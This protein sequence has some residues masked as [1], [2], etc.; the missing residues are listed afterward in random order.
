MFDATS[1]YDV[2]K[3]N[4]SY[5]WDFGD[6]ETSTEPVVTHIYEK[7]GQYTVK[8]T[9][10][11]DSG[12]PCDSASTTQTVYVNTPPKASFIGPSKV[13]KDDGVSFDASATTDDT[14]ENLTYLWNFGDGSRGEGE[15]VSHVYGKGGS[16]NVTLTVDDNSGTSCDMDSVVKQIKV[17]TPPVAV[18]GRDITMCLKDAEADYT[19]YLDGTSSRDAD[20]DQLKYTW[21]LG[22]GTT[23]EGA[24]VSHTYAKGGIYNVTLTVDDGSGLACSSSSDSIKVDLNKAPV[25]KAGGDKKAC[26]GDTVS[27]DGSSSVSDQTQGRFAVS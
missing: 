16:Y 8:L 3:Q 4:L 27:F 21:N 7:G 10:T 12:L 19:V 18:A 25:A 9:V 14:P 15:K 11:D 6:G 24:K 1:S 22:D 5:L 17:N 23:K 20:G 2:D 13:C 26:A